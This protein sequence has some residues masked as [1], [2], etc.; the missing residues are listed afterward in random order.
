MRRLLTLVVVSILLI[1]FVSVQGEEQGPLGW[2]QSAGGFD[3]ETLAGHVVLD[4]NSIIVAGQYTSSATFGDDG[5]GATGFEGDSDIFVAKMDASG[6]WTSV[7][8]FGSSGTDGIDAI[9]L[10]PS[11]DIILAGHFCIGTA[12]MSCE[13]NMSTQTLVKGSEQGEGDAFVG[14]FSYSAGQ[15]NIIWIRTISNDNDLSALDISISPSGGISVGI[16]HRDIIEVEDKIVPGSGGLSL[17]ILHYDENGGIVWVNG[18]SSPNDLEP[19]GGMCYSD[20]GY[21]HVTGT[22]IGAVMF[23][24]TYDSEGGADIFAAQLD[25]DGNF[26][27]TSFAGSTGDDWSNDCAIDSNGQMHIVGQFENTANFGFINVTSNGWWDMFHAVLSPLGAWQEVSSSGGGGWESLESIILDSRDNAIVVGSY[28]ANFTLGVDTLS[29]RDSNGDRRDV[30]VAQFDSNNQ[31]LWAISAGGLGDDRGV[32]VQFGENESPIIGMEIQ[33]TAQMSNFTVNS[34]GSYDIALWNY[35]RDHDSDGLTDG[36][37]NC[38]R[39]ANPAQQD[40]DGDLFGDACDDDDDGDAVGDDWDDCTPGETG[41]NSAP[42]TD[43]DSD[44]C[45]DETEDFDDDED[46]ILD[47]YDDCPKGPVGW[48]STIANDENQDG[49]EDLDSDGD[50]YVDQLDKCPAIDDDQADLDGDGIG[51]ACET[52]TDGDGIIDTL[53]NCMRDDFSW[54]SIHEIDHDQDGCRDLDRDAD[55]DGDN[56]LDLSD[57]CPTGE[58]NWNSSFDHDNDGCHDDREDFDDDSDG[59]EDSVDTCPRGYVGISGVGMD[60]DQDGCVDSIEDD[61]DDN[62]GVLDASDE[63]RFTPPNLEVEANGCSGVQLDDDNDGVHNLND[64][65]PAT[66]LGETVSSTG[67][68]VQT[69]EEK[70]ESQDDS[71]TSSSL[72]WI[73]FVIAGVLVVVALIVTFRPQKPLPVKQIPSVK[74]ESTVDDGRGQGDSSATS[75]DFSSTGLDVDASQPQLVTDKN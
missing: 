28:T 42:N 8:G 63:C 56:L 18:I 20:S 24:E 14:R 40:T 11:G 25:G 23:I 31:W 35:A 50:G 39:V 69:D 64:L 3:D 55:D 48:L 61:D 51:D 5:I 73:L 65:C 19:F 2:A 15:L 43:H 12:G 7:Q 30:L 17:A 70:T 21:L 33:N 58:I 75:A 54:E 45:R 52:D 47:L 74:P 68:T 62:D 59:Y 10:H 26:T 1:P 29:D 38:P 72:T 41:W 53:D 9:A 22:F 32:S 16:F 36:A 37:D 44:G 4:D 60:F 6:N 34:A 66:P 71:E 46:G 67:C 57:D 49:C 27:W 13:M